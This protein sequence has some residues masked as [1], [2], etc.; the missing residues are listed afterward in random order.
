MIRPYT[1]GDERDITRLY[2]LVF[3]QQMDLEHW[4]WRYKENPVGVLTINLAEAEEGLVG[5]Y[6]VGPINMKVGDRLCTAALS[7]DTMVHPDYRH[8]GMF[9]ELAKHLYDRVACPGIPLIYGFPN[10]SSHHGF[11]ARLGWVDLCNRVPIFLKVLDLKAIL[12]AKIGDNPFLPLLAYIGR[13]GLSVLSPTRPSELPLGCTIRQ[14]AS[15]DERLDQLWE[16]A[17]STLNI[18]VVRDQRYLNWRYVEKPDDAYTIFT[19]E[20]ADQLVGYAVLK[21]VDKFGLRMGF[22]VDLLSLP[23]RPDI[24]RSLVSRAMQYFRDSQADIVCSLT[25]RHGPLFQALNASGFLA[26]PTRLHP[27]EMYLGVRRNA[28]EYSAEFITDPNNWHITWGDHDDI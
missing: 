10:K 16:H 20:T 3:G 1:D 24:C 18:A 22:V 7:L 28:Q 21:C 13:T 14:V 17:S 11:V 12:C 4:R 15:F 23:D 26:L 8:Q 6:A 5:H 9:V 2:H 25:L 27:Q 19:V